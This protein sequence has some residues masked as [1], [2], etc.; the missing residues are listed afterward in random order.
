MKS[1][2]SSPGQISPDQN[3]GSAYGQSNGQTTRTADSNNPLGS[4]RGTGTEGEN[5]LS[6]ATSGEGTGSGESQVVRGDDPGGSGGHRGHAVQAP[7]SAETATGATADH[8][9]PPAEVTNEGGEWAIRDAGVLP[10]RPQPIF[11]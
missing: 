11:G 6:G 2:E 7:S 3:S 8:I 1:K 4:G 5:G 9:G 10:T